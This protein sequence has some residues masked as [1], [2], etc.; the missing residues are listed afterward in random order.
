MPRIQPLE[1]AQAPAEVQ[2][3]YDN[4]QQK[5][6]TVPNIFKTM[7][8]SPATLNTYFAIGG[9]LEKGTL[10]AKVG[11]QIALAVGQANKCGYCL[12]AHT[13]I[14]K[15][16]GLTDQEITAARDSAASDAKANGAVKLAAAIVRTQGNVS[17][18]DLAAARKAGLSEGEILETLTHT[19]KNIFT[20]YFN[21]LA[22]TEI[23]F[24]KAPN[25][26]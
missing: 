7:A 2:A 17:D 6:G 3:T 24:P 21:H 18:A 16:V 10:G 1:K 15:N 14:G 19:V 20:N 8:H 5:L 22:A 11:E 23:D 9:A 4:L 26:P 12:S 13:A 25:L